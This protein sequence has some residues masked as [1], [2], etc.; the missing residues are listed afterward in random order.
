MSASVTRAGVHLAMPAEHPPTRELVLPRRPSEQRILGRDESSTP[1]RRCYA[2]RA[3][4]C[5]LET[6]TARSR[7]FCASASACDGRR[8]RLHSPETSTALA[9][10]LCASLAADIASQ[11]RHDLGPASQ[12]RN[13]TRVQRRS[14]RG[15]VSTGS[16]KPGGSRSMRL[17]MASSK[18]SSATDL[19]WLASSAST[20]QKIVIAP[21]SSIPFSHPGVDAQVGGPT[22]RMSAAT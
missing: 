22:T 4:R 1:S 16:S 7:C 11:S 2:M 14:T 3:S 19:A 13:R 10:G 9:R 8:S 15:S 17:W 6:S 18:T 5:T 21:G 20:V 12:A